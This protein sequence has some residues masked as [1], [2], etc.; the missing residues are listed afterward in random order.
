MP[1][2]GGQAA[3][4]EPRYSEGFWEEYMR[5]NLGNGDSDALLPLPS[6]NFEG[7]GQEMTTG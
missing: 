5:E 7:S 2:G 3:L 1:D 4:G 6:L